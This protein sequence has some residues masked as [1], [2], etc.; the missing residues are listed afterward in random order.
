MAVVLKV[1]AETDVINASWDPECDG[2]CGLADSLGLM[3]YEGTQ[4]L[5][6]VKNYAAGSQQWQVLRLHC[7]I[8]S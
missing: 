8:A 4:A 5:N 7:S 2:D 3:V 6:Y 1:E